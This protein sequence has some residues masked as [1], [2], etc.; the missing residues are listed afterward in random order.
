MPATIGLMTT[1]SFDVAKPGE[2]WTDQGLV[3]MSKTGDDFN[4]IDPFRIDLSDGRATLAYGSFWSGVKLRELDAEN[5]VR[6]RIALQ[7][8]PAAATEGVIPELI[9]RACGILTQIH[10]F[11]KLL[12][13]VERERISWPL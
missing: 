8:K 3:L 6:A 9:V 10:C 12:G 2:G 5:L 4:A 7:A 13:C 1:A 11:V